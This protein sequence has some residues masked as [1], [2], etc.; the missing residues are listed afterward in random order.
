MDYAAFI[1]SAAGG[2]PPVLTLIHGADA[3]L[4]DD[5]LATATRGLFADASEIA[6]GRDVLEG[7]EVTAD[8]VFPDGRRER[9]HSRYLFPRVHPEDR[10]RQPIDW[11][12]DL[13]AGAELEFGV[14]PGPAGNGAR[15]WVT[16]G[17]LT[18]K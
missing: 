9:L 1:R 2:R 12:F 11:T 6:L 13:P 4:L 17:Y 8:A 16:L 15:D 14:N 7:G 5:A 10:G 3:Q 18:I